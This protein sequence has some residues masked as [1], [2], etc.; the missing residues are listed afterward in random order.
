MV[1]V[2]FPCCICGC[3]MA[4]PKELYSSA[5]RS[6]NIWFY[7]GYGHEQRFMTRE[8][9]EALAKKKAASA[10]DNVVAFPKGA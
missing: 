4:L 2:G 8:E 5:I 1:P 7:C 3:D 9:M 10:G 6:P